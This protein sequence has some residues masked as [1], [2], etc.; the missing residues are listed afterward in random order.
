MNFLGILFRILFV[1][2][3]VSLLNYVAPFL[4]NHI[5]DYVNDQ[6][7]KIYVG[8]LMVAGLVFSRILLSILIARIHMLLVKILLLSNQRANFFLVNVGSED[9]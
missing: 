6:D 4:M 5:I 7:R 1:A 3:I 8:A 9:I 2:L